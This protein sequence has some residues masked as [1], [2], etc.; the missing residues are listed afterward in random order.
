ME[1]LK[2]LIDLVANLPA[3]ALWVLVGFFAYKVV[4]IGSIYGVIRFVAGRLFDWLQQRKA[5]EVEYK[6][7][8][9][10]LEGMCIKA[11]TDRLIAQLN[12]LRGKG[13][14]IESDYIHSQSVDW[15]RDAI[16][17]KIDREREATLR[18]VA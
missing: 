14:N 9:P 4:I 8:R 1:E 10:M 15:L 16:D 3:M 13:L 17:Q 18:K 5:R 12:R 6:E 11:E 7:I 2:L